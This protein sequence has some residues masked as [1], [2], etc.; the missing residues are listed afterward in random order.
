[1]PAPVRCTHCGHPGKV[2]NEY[3][4]KRIKCKQCGQGF[5]AILD[6]SVQ[7]HAPPIAPPE[8]QM[9][10]LAPSLPA[11]VEQTPQ[12]VPCPYCGEQILPVAKKCKHCQTSLDQLPAAPPPQQVYFPSPEQPPRQFPGYDYSQPPPAPVVN[13]N[14]TTVASAHAESRSSSSSGG[15]CSG[16]GAILIFLAGSVVAFFFCCGGLSMVGNQANKAMQSAIE[17]PPRI[18]TRPAR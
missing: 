5:V 9:P 13:V 16:C 10:P 15:F 17:T 11:V 18:P 6:A 4:G 12:T 3:L 14:V 7:A 2:P 1:M 8:P